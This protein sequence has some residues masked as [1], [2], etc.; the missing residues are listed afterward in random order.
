MLIM[1]KGIITICLFVVVSLEIWSQSFAL[2]KITNTISSIKG[3]VYNLI[4]LTKKI[5]NPE[6]KSEWNH[7]EGVFLKDM[8]AHLNSVLEELNYTSVHDY[9]RLVR[10]N[11]N[12]IDQQAVS[13]NQ[14]TDFENYLHSVTSDSDYEIRALKKEYETKPFPFSIDRD[15]NAISKMTMQIQEYEQRLTEYQKQLNAL[16]TIAQLNNRLQEIRREKLEPNVALN[17]KLKKQLEDEEATIGKQKQEIDKERNRLTSLI[18]DTQTQI[19]R[20]NLDSYIKD[21]DKTGR[22]QLITSVLTSFDDF[23]EWEKFFNN[24][25]TCIRDFFVLKEIKQKLYE[26]LDNIPQGQVQS[27]SSKLDAFCTGWG[28]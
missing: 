23:Y 5:G 12:R 6:Y 25:N 7:S 18:S 9:V 11:I 1:K 17:A 21:M 15:E 2:P 28:I 13:R 10:T 19:R 24:E 4:E 27:F 16:P 3:G 20:L 22:D 8:V 26:L 14:M